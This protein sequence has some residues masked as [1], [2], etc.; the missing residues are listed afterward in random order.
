MQLIK[1]G[2]LCAVLLVSGCETV[3]YEYQA[4]ENARGKQCVVQC[5]SIRETCRSNENQRVQSEKRSCERRSETTYLVCM[6][7]ANSNKDQQAACNKKRGQCYGYPSYQ[8][9]NDDYN[10]CFSNC[11]GVVKKIVEKN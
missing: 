11:G 7:K 4:P 9:C 8:L 5:A 1:I 10:Q 6:D 3:R 2:A